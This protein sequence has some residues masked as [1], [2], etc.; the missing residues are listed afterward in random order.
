MEHRVK[1]DLG[2]D[3]AKKATVA[4]LAAYSQRFSEYQ[5]K[6]TWTGEYT[7]K[8]NFNVKGMS[9]D[10]KFE[11]ADRE[12]TMD[13]DVPFLLRPFKAKALDVIEREITE[14]CARAK[15]GEFG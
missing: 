9:L 4:A 6:S 14:W 1:H 8:V 12:I 7:A 5:P 11:V 2:K 10:G 15:A 13:L 3:L